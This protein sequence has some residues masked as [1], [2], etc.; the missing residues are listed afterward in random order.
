M[1]GFERARRCLKDKRDPG[2]RHLSDFEDVVKSE[3]LFMHDWNVFVRRF[4]PFADKELPD[5][6]EAF[7]HYRGKN[8]AKNPELRR[9]FTLHLVNAWDF[10]VIESGVIDKV[11]KVVDSYC[12]PARA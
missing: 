9:L 1:M 7:A 12:S 8:M 10:A 2:L 6:Y 11:L 5:A 3:K 4:K